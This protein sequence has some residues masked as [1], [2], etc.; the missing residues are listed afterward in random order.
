MYWL[1]D[2]TDYV[3]C[4]IEASYK[5]KTRGTLLAQ[6]CTPAKALYDTSA[7]LYEVSYNQCVYVTQL[8][9]IPIP[10]SSAADNFHVP[11]A[12]LHATQPIALCWQFHV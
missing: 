9:L 5:F 2:D 8:Y 11:V 12:T 7:L 6:F 1:P 10:E 4:K 3:G